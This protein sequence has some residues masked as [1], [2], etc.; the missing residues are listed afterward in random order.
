MRIFISV[1]LLIFSLQSFSK[2]DD[3]RDFE[4]EGISIGDSVLDFFTEE[5]IK[6]N[7]WHYY[8]NNEYTPLQFDYPSF[9]TIYDAIDIQYKTNDKNYTIKGL[10]GIIFYT[11][12][13]K[14]N[15]CYKRMDTIISE[16]R[17]MFSKLDEIPKKTY[18]HTGIDDGG[19]STV[20]GMAFEFKNQDAINIQCYNYSVESKDQNHLR[21]G[22]NTSDYRYFLSNKA[23]N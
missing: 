7:T 10:S 1:L 20:T 4:I 8:K 17:S 23:Y 18:V 6:K 5:E 22:I 9:A 11:D 12:K 21:I 14:I 16:I 3:I 13:R 19:K 2:A 15:E